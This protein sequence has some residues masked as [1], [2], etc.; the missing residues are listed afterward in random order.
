MARDGLAV[1]PFAWPLVDAFHYLPRFA[2]LR[3]AEAPHPPVAHARALAAALDR[4]WSAAVFHAFLSEPDE[5]FAVLRDH[6]AAVRERVDRGELVTG[7]CRELAAR[8]S[9]APC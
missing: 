8:V 9:S 2:S 5:R 6:L 1:L 7:P 4:P 3:G